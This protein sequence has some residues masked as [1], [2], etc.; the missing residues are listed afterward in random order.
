MSVPVTWALAE[1]LGEARRTGA[2]PAT[3]FD[4][5]HAVR[6]AAAM[7]GRLPT[8][9]EWE[10][11]AGGG[12]RRYPWGDDEPGYDGPL[13]A[14]LR[15]LGLGGPSPVGSFPDGATPDGVLDVAGNVWEWTATAVPGGR[16]VRGGSYRSISL[17]ARCAYVNEVPAGLVSPG[18]GV[19]VVS[20][21]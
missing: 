15:G 6:I 19:R 17:Y 12:H 21:A 8:S 5:P 18:I 9:A 4:W 10:W 16:V 11:M 7:G 2:A 3:G 20:D 14:N 13:R 1:D